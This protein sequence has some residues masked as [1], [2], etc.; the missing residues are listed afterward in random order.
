V[1]GKP[2][3][4]AKSVP[5]FEYRLDNLGGYNWN[6]LNAKVPQF[7]SLPSIYAT[8]QL[9]SE[10]PQTR[11]VSSLLD[12]LQTTANTV[13]L[14]GGDRNASLPKTIVQLKIASKQV[15][16]K[17]L[18]PF[19]VGHLQPLMVKLRFVRAKSMVCNNQW[20]FDKANKLFRQHLPEKLYP[21]VDRLLRHVQPG[22]NL[23]NVL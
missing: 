21:T 20:P 2:L 18:D 10:L 1:S 9:E 15:L 11:D 17:S 5:R 13:A 14:I 19:K 7:D 6:Q 3:I 4:D 12:I 23:I 16:P 8:A 22:V